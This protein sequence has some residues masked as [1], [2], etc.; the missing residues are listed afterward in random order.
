M[1]CFNCGTKVFETSAFCPQCGSNVGARKA[2][3]QAGA[4]ASAATASAVAAMPAVQTPKRAVTGGARAQQAA[5]Q[6]VHA[7]AG[8]VARVAAKPDGMRWA[9][10]AAA[11]L[12][13]M[14]MLMPW[15]KVEG[16]GKVN[17]ALGGFGSLLGTSTPSMQ[18]E[19]TAL[20]VT[21][22]LDW[23]HSMVGSSDIQGL[24]IALTGAWVLA[25]GLLVAGL[26][27][28]FVGKR[29]T[30]LLAM[31]G[32]AV[33]AAALVWAAALAL[34]NASLGMKLLGITPWAA[35]TVLAGLAAV[36]CALLAHTRRSTV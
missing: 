35:M 13:A 11:A 30:A 29:T 20:D 3:V 5:A 8:S 28:S 27:A 25:L 10:R 36:V 24:M 19:F 6:P 15:V 26:V 33:A 12:A 32:V 7:S 34:A 4:G 23:V 1:F 16:V 9:A 21:K 31:G 2:T 17:E 18:E 22:L 14:F